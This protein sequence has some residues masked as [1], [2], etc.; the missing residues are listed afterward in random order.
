MYREK[1]AIGMVRVIKNRS[2]HFFLH[3]ATQQAQNEGISSA[4]SSGQQWD[5]RGSGPHE[6][7]F[8]QSP[9]EVRGNRL[10]LTQ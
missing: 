6:Q 2:S 3:E 5:G 9:D 4:F 8:V 7:T 10:P 1:E